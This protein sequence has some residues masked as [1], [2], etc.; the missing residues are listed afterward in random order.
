MV[1]QAT[2]GWRGG[3]ICKAQI[4]VEGDKTGQGAEADDGV[5]H[6]SEAEAGC[7]EICI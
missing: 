1:Q 5:R 6:L 7:L 2:I 3:S 4:L